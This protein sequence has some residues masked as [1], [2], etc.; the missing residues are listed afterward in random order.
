[1]AEREVL[2][3]AKYQEVFYGIN[4]S[5][6]EIEHSAEQLKGIAHAM[7]KEAL[8]RIKLPPATNIPISSEAPA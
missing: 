3:D 4:M 1:M 6:D 8:S 7:H 5:L 2:M